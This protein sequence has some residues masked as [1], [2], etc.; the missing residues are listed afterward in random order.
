MNSGI[1][2][3]RLDPV[4]EKQIP[5]HAISDSYFGRWAQFE[6]YNPDSV[7]TTK[8]IACFGDSTTNGATLSDGEPSTW[9]HLLDASYGW[10]RWVFNGGY[11]GGNSTTIRAVF[12]AHANT[13]QAVAIILVG[14][15]ESRGDYV[16]CK[17]NVAAMV[18][19]LP[20]DHYIIGSVLC[21][22]DLED[23]YVASTKAH[24]AYMAMLYGSH[25]MATDEALAAA[26]DPQNSQDVIDVAGGRVPGSLRNDVIH[27]NAAGNAVYF[28]A[29]K[30][31][32]EALGY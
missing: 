28:A 8:D 24:N 25:Y 16:A 4:G 30:A 1:P 9:R 31:K 26:Y 12:D 13:R 2:T 32:I 18:A 23:E 17:A 10:S 27:L 5:E 19:A 22:A 20:H 29:V 21:S 7:W 6:R 3:V 14:I 15:N 11:D